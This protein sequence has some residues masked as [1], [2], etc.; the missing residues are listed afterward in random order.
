MNEFEN[1]IENSDDV[2]SNEVDSVS[3][4]P[5]VTEVESSED[6]DISA[7]AQALQELDSSST[8]SE[9]LIAIQ[10]SITDLN[11][12]LLYSNF[13]L[14][15]ILLFVMLIFVRNIFTRFFERLKVR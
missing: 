10:D 14:S 6:L 4:D 2:I 3:E 5:E 11:N 1:E 9:E 12:N 7:L 15:S 8:S 13:L